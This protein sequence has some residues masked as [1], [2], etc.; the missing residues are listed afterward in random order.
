M[1]PSEYKAIY[2]DTEG[3]F[4]TE[5]IESIAKARGLDPAKILKNIQ[6]ANP[7]NRT[8]QESYVEAACCAIKSDSKIKLLIVDSMTAHYRVDYPG[9]SRLPERQQRL[10]K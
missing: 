5:R 2:I 4:R 3:T 8:Q 9:R 7:L 6:I 1:F 10:N